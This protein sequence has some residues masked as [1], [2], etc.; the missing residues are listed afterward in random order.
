MNTNR[1]VCNNSFSFGRLRPK[2][3]L[4]I[5]IIRVIRSFFY[6]KLQSIGSIPCCI[7]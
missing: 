6:Y 7:K 1:I 4:P 3:R 5:R 2:F